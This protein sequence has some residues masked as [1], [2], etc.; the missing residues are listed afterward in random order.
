MDVTVFQ[1]RDTYITPE[2]SQQEPRYPVCVRVVKHI[3]T[4]YNI[5][6]LHSTYRITRQYIFWWSWSLLSLFDV[7]LFVMN[8]ANQNHVLEFYHYRSYMSG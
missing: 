4:L 6:V 3:E 7:T 2:R 5:T 1:F 8:K